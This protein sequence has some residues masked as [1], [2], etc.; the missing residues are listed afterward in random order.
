MFQEALQFCFAIVLCYNKQTPMRLTSRMPPPLTWQL[1]QIIVDCLFAC[2]LNQSRGHWL[3]NDALHSTISMSLKLKKEHQ[4]VLSFESL[5]EEDSTIANE[6]ALLVFNIRKEVCGVLDSFLSFLTKY[7][8]K[9]THNMISL[10]L[11]LRFKNLQI[12]FSFVGW[13]QIVSLVQAYD[14][15]SLYPMLVKCYEHLHPLIRSNTNLVD[16]YNFY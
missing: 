10:M 2:I 6:L 15:K 16:Q 13:E 4:I 11:D 14:R 12:I 7:K 3:L 8:N 9:K 1:C 5:M